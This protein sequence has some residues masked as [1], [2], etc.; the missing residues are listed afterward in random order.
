MDQ[1]LIAMGYP[2]FVGLLALEVAWSHKKGLGLY[3]FADAL[4]D[5]A[6]GV[7]SQAVGLI[8]A[9]LGLAI[10]A[11][12]WQFRL[13]TLPDDHPATWLGALVLVDLAFYWWHRMSHESC[14]LWATHVVHHQSEDYNLAVAL[15]Q[16][17]GTHLTHV[18]FHLPMALLGFSPKMLATHVAISLLYQFWIHTE[19]IRRMGPFEWLFNAPMH[20]RVHHAINPQYLDKNYGGILIVW[21]RLFGT[22]EAEVEPCVYGTVKPLAS[23]NTVWANLIVWHHMLAVSR[24]TARLADKL[25]VWLKSPAW[26]PPDVPGYAP[27]VVDRARVVKYETASTPR[28][29]FW[30]LAQFLLTMAVQAILRKAEIPVIAVAV[31]LILWALLNLGGLLEH[32]AWAPRSEV[33]RLVVTVAVSL[34]FG[35]L[36][37]PWAIAGPVAAVSLGL[38]LSLPMAVRAYEQPPDVAPQSQR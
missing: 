4:T 9:F 38:L 8:V 17:W 16:E 34:G 36:G 33:A 32:K 5:L 12:L 2:F 20:H 29:R 26:S 6:C 14:V 35:A 22:Y 13:F 18:P 3:R 21:D 19:V 10:Y 11:W 27:Q 7:S 1:D 31:A 30:L 37:Q 24:Q 15:R 23:W 28:L 25:R